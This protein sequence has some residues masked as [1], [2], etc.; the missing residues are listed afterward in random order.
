M[1][2]VAFGK[3]LLLTSPFCLASVYGFSLFIRWL[4]PTGVLCNTSRTSASRHAHP[5][6]LTFQVRLFR[7]HTD[8]LF[9]TYTHSLSDEPIPLQHHRISTPGP[10]FHLRLAGVEQPPSKFARHSN[11]GH[12]GHWICWP[13]VHR[14]RTS[15]LGAYT[16][17][18]INKQPF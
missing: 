5:C 10:H 9:H 2:A 11:W 14:L 12:L 18:R 17:A 16:C 6:R 15:F 3:T 8:T 1:F 7:L 4:S 13:I